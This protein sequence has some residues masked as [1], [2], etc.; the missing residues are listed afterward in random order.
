[1]AIRDAYDIGW[2]PVQYL[3]NLSIS[4]GSVL[5]PAGLDKAA[6]VLSVA[7]YKDP[8]DKQWE[9]DPAIKEWTAFM[10]KYYPEGRRT[11]SLNV[12]GYALAQLLVQ[13]LRQ[14]GD[15]LTRANVM[16][17][18]ANLRN[19]QLPVALPGVL[20]NTGPADF[21][22]FESMQMQRFDGKQWTLFGEVMGR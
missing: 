16:R 14:A 6:G 8:T 3:N 19:L 1:M 22:P 17:Q 2:H 18:A 13:V 15:N 5:T 9:D 21:F 12:Y 10:K 20:I 4:V 7:Y 11:D